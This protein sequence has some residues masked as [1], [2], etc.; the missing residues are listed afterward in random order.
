MLY[1]KKCGVTVTGGL[2]RCPLCQGDLSGQPEPESEKFPVIGAM[3]QPLAGIVR[4]LGFLTV[5]AAAISVGVNYA[6]QRNNWWSLFVLA[7]MGC[8]WLSFGLIIKKRRNLP[9]TILWQVGLISVLSVL[10]DWAT[11][12]HRWSLDYVIPILNIAAIV[13][14]VVVARVLRMHIEDYILYFILDCVLGLVPLVLL[15]TNQLRVLL[16]ALLCIILSVVALAGLLIFEGTAMRA[17]LYRR[18]RL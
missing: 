4:L 5:V 15:V 10:W 12:F 1:C 17:E 9:K 16:P 8:A 14:S 2:T 18:T 7:G 6:Y 13:G 11:G 3:S